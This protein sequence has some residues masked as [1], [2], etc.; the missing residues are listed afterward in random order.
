M[1][2]RDSPMHNPKIIDVK[3]VI[4]VNDEPTA[5]KASEPRYF[6]TINVSATLYNCCKRFPKIIGSENNNKDLVIF[7]SVSF[8]STFLPPFDISYPCLLYTSRT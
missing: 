5:A 4:S 3:K 1:C 8:V 7:P 6:P 2:I